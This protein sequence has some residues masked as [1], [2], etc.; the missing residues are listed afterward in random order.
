MEIVWKIEKRI[1][2]SYEKVEN[3]SFVH[4]IFSPIQRATNSSGI[5]S[6]LDIRV[7]RPNHMNNGMNN[8]FGMNNGYGRP[9]IP[10]GAQMSRPACPPRNNFPM[11]NTSVPP[12]RITLLQKP[13]RQTPPTTAQ[14]PQVTR[15]QVI[16]I[17]K[18]GKCY[19]QCRFIRNSVKVPILDVS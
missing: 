14:Q 15:P 10:P 12:P 11:I 17:A 8:A 9:G 16:S 4:S 7:P 5:P 13:H 2:N 18:P 6:L 1:Q 3:S 19:T